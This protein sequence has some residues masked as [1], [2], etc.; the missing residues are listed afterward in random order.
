MGLA[1]K[2]FKR[3]KKDFLSGKNLQK[4]K[5]NSQKECVFINS[6]LKLQCHVFKNKLLQTGFSAILL[7]LKKIKRVR[8][9]I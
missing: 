6:A 3:G 4:K 1:L 5:K 7:C 2:V 9:F 8:L